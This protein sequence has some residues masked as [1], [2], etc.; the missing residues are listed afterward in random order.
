MSRTATAALAL[1]V[2]LAA[3]IPL[4]GRL[5]SPAAAP[6]AAAPGTAFSAVPDAIGAQDISGPYEAVEGWPQDLATLPGHEK[7]TYGGARGIF[8]E[9]PN[10]VFLL[11][12]GELP[13]I[14]RPQTRLFP[15]IGPNVQFPL[16]GLP[17]RNA[18][19]ATPPGAGGSG[20]DPARGMD[21]WRGAAAPFRE[22]GVDARWE[23]CLIV[24]DAQGNI[25]EEWTQGEKW[26]KR[27]HSVYISPYDAQKHVWVVDD[28]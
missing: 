9:S 28:H 27:P 4:G 22:L 24:V 7:W 11:G 21:L 10:R 16:A 23:H 26:F 18:N 15:D 14:A 17:W 5:M 12:G 13:K 2:G 6:A 25:I 3:G 20:Q 1:V 19:T 8:A